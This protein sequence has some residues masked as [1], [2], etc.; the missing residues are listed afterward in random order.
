MTMW[1]DNIKFVKVKVS[2]EDDFYYFN[3]FFLWKKDFAEMHT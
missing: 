1:A 3:S 2:C